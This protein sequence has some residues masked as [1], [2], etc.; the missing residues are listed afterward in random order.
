MYIQEEEISALEERLWA[1]REDFVPFEC[2]LHRMKDSFSL[3]EDTLISTISLGYDDSQKQSLMN[4]GG[5]SETE[6]T[7]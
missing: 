4:L 1:A 2:D 7:R 6:L 3:E 5:E